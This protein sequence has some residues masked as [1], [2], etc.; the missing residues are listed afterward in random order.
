MRFF[1]KQ[2]NTRSLG[3][4]RVK[5]TEQSTSRVD[6]SVPLR[7]HDPRD[8]GLICLVKKRKISFW[9]L[10]DLKIQYWILKEKHPKQIN[11]AFLW[12]DP[13]SD[14][15]S[16][17]CLDH[18]A[19]KEPANPVMDSPVPLMH[20]DPDRSRITDPNSDHPKG[21]HSPVPLMHHGL[22]AP[23]SRQISDHPKG[24]HPKARIKKL[25]SVLNARSSN[26]QNSGSGLFCSFDAPWSEIRY[27][28]RVYWA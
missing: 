10:S 5:G 27:C 4:W 20:H 3:S 15:W 21:T 7:H 25:I 26:Y 13:S 19:S 28:F 17:I 18:G 9:I 22:S 23:W 12:G 1:T 11:G 6:S 2:I 14:Q 8:L 24:T 16:K